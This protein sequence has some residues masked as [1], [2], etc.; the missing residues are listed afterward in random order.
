MLPHRR[1]R[2]VSLLASPT[3][4]KKATDQ[5]A[6]CRDLD[7]R[8]SED[9]PPCEQ[10]DS[11]ILAQLKKQGAPLTCHVVSENRHL[12]VRDLALADALD[13][14]VG[15]MHGTL[16]ICVPGKLA[17]YEGEE[18]GERYILHREP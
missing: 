8:Y 5:L 13:E 1:E 6:H 11:K 3:R 15:G 4:R 7:P 18:P 10:A 2:W 9:I 14:V 16:V 12:D 17:Y